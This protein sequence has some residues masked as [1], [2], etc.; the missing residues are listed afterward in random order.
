MVNIVLLRKRDQR[1]KGASRRG[2]WVPFV[3]ASIYHRG[4]D[5][6]GEEEGKERSS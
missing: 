2:H 5:G 1:G 4:E 3:K 6:E